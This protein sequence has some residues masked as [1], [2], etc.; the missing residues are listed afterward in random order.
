MGVHPQHNIFAFLVI[1]FLPATIAFFFASAVWIANKRPAIAPWR[2]TSFNCALGCALADMVLFMPN[3]A[4]FLATQ[5]PATGI[6]LVTNWTALSLLVLVLGASLTG[7]GWSRGLLFC[8]G[9]LLFL[10]V[11]MVYAT[12][13]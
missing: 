2:I 1:A 13:P 4:R 10:G 3:S 9:L 7:K 11:F 8:W 5:A 12:V 6:W